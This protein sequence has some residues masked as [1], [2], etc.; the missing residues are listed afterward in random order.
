MLIEELLQLV[1][2]KKKALESRILTLEAN[3]DIDGLAVN[4]SLIEETEDTITK[5]ES[6]ITL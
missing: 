6:L 1:K 2:N 5:L 4:T 3:G